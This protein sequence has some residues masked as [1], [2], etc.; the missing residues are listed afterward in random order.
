MEELRRHLQE[1]GKTESWIGL[2]KKFNYL[3]GETDKKRSDAVRKLFDQIQIN[4][5]EMHIVLGCVHVPF[6]NQELFKSLISF[7]SDYKDK[8]KGFHLIGDFLD[9]KSLSSH[10]DGIVDKSGLTLGKEYQ[11][12]NEVLD[13]FDNIL[14]INISK[15]FIFGNHEDRYFRIINSTKASKFADALISPIDGLNLKSRGY[16]ILTDW[17]EDYITV[18]KYQLF[19]GIF[20]TQTPAKSHITKLK[21]SCMFAHTHRI[22]QYYEKELHGLNIGTMCDIESS[23]FKYLSRLERSLWRNGFGII[24]VNKNQSQAEIVTCE[25]NHFFYGGK[26]Y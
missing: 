4:D 2:A 7:L 9:L 25:N 12:G 24:Y 13:L 3:E 14:N 8:I 15:S 23:G 16:K 19:H 18:G 11:T 1:K 26:L 21:K 6:H 10:D 17:K 22:D 20:C 5:I